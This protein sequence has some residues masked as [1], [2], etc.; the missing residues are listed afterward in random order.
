MSINAIQQNLRKKW[1]ILGLALQ[2]CFAGCGHSTLARSGGR[3]LG[4]RDAN[5]T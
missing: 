4:E 5:S 1:T 2:F 3:R